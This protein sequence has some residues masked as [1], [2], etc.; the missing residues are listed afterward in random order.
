MY[1]GLGSVVDQEA[2]LT[3]LNAGIERATLALESG[4]ARALLDRWVAATRA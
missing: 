2:V 1:E 3:A 4:A